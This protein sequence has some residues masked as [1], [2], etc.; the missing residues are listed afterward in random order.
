VREGEA[1]NTTA[2]LVVDMLNDFF[3]SKKGLPLAAGAEQLLQNCRKVVLSARSAGIPVVFVNDSFQRTEI[4]IDRHFK[5]SGSPHAI[6]GTEEARVV[7][8]L[9][10]DPDRD[11]VVGKKLYDGFYNTRLDSILREMEIKE[12]VFAGVYTH[13]C[14]QHTVMGAFCRGYDTVVLRDCVSCADLKVQEYSL[15][16]MK[17]YYLAQLVDADAWISGISSQATQ[18]RG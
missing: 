12:C 5:A 1:V 6:E 18:S 7:K 2:L 17:K 9:S 15:G 13:C 16:Y 3:I 10:Y 14:V 8:E 4:P 11:F